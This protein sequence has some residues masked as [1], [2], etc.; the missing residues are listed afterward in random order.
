MASCSACALQGPQVSARLA[1]LEHQ[2]FL[3]PQAKTVLLERLAQRE[4]LAC[5]AL[6]VSQVRLEI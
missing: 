6:M 2:G 4:R 5:P 3:V 1:C